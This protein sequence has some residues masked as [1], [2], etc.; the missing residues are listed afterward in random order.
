MTAAAPLSFRAAVHARPAAATIG[1]TRLLRGL[2]VPTLD[3]S[4][5]DALGGFPA[6]FEEVEAAYS[7][8]S[9]MFFEPDGS[10]VW[11]SSA[12]ETPWQLDGLVFDR[13]GRV[14]YVELMGTCPAERLETLL[15]P[16]GWPRQAVLFQLLQE[17]VFLAEPEFRRYAA[18]T[19]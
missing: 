5:A 16:L 19:G 1:P 9:R 10:F 4:P 15:A 2:D 12:E 17:A 3:V 13:D 8:E 18:A 11:R 7:R 14:R 6:T